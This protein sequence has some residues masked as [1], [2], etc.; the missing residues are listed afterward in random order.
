MNIKYDG[1]TYCVVSEETDV[2]R[3]KLL[4]KYL[5]VIQYKDE[6]YLKIWYSSAIFG[7]FLKE[8]GTDKVDSCFI[9]IEENQKS[10]C[11]DALNKLVCQDAAYGLDY[12]D[13]FTCMG[14]ELEN[15]CHF[16][17]EFTVHIKNG[18]P[19]IDQLDEVKELISTAKH[20]IILMDGNL[21]L[22]DSNNIIDT[23]FCDDDDTDVLV[24]LH[25]DEKYEDGR[26]Y[27]W[28]R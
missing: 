18:E 14:N 19:I 7:M 21:S 5:F 23:L 26:I 27:L 22:M 24:Q 4:D 9:K 11:I 17:G 10:T 3:E 1:Q 13:A 6:Q 2:I 15:P 8:E 16:F 28:V 20:I 25:E 12:R